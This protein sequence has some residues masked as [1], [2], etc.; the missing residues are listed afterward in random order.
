M[1]VYEGK[2]DGKQL[3]IAIIVS[4]FNSFLTQKL[5]DGAI[6]CLI[7]HGVEKDSISLIWAPGSFEIPQLI[8]LVSK[9]KP[10]AIITLGVIIKGDT[11][12]FEYVASQTTKGISEL[13]IELQ[14]PISFGIVTAENLEQAIERCGTKQGN[15]GFDA[16]MTAI[17]MAN[18]FKT[19]K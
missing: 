10:D 8:K 14:I 12:H 13:S 18:L 17:E 6:D 11:P 3:K 5:L 15:K 16:A 2:L 1:K 4:R 19:I 9:T 7:R